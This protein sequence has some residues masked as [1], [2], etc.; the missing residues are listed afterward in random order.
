MAKRNKEPKPITISPLAKADIRTVLNY[1]SQHWNQKVIDEFLQKL[2]TFYYIIAINPR[3]F[4]FYNKQKNIRKYVLDKNNVIYYRNKKEGIEII[5]L[6]NSKQQPNKL[7][8][9]FK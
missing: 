8:K 9:I 6:F 5:T 2:S 3:L 7:K 1:L 4:G